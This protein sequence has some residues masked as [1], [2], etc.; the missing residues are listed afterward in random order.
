MENMTIQYNIGFKNEEG[1]QKLAANDKPLLDSL[2]GS[3]AQD[4]TGDSPNGV[5]HQQMMDI[6]QKAG[7]KSTDYIPVRVGTTPII[8]PKTGQQAKSPEGVPLTENSWKLYKDQMIKI[9]PEQATQ[10]SGLPGVQPIAEGQEIR[11]S[12]AYQLQTEVNRIS[13]SSLAITNQLK[14]NKITNGAPLDPKD[15]NTARAL[16]NWNTALAQGGGDPTKAMDIMGKK[17]LDTTPIVKAYGGAENMQKI[18]DGLV[19]KAAADKKTAEANAEA[20]TPKGRTDQA[21]KEQDLANK[22]LEGKKLE[23]DVASGK[24]ITDSL[25]HT[26]VPPEGGVKEYNKRQGTFKKDAD[27]LAKTEGTFNQFSDILKDINDGKDISGAKSVV[28]LFNAIGISAEPIAGKGFRITSNIIQE[29]AEARGLGEELYQKLLSLKDGEVITP[30]QI[31]DYGEIALRSRHDAYVNKINEA[32]AQGISP[33]FLLPRGNGRK[34][35]A[36]T[37]SIYYDTAAGNSP[38]EKSANA[39]A[40]AKKMG[41]QF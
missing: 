4:L 41:W 31:K 25:G 26:I 30:Q 37:A 3:N 15:A 17:N 7:G 21:I 16:D 10:Y 18:S 9:S 28:A 23:Q 20:A 2:A 40:A 1:L 19:A 11:A 38:Q 34:V 35:D 12:K 5:G 8:D 27:N 6:L 24:T 13:G 39:Q 36:N 29:H 22:K 32:Q 14:D 33:D